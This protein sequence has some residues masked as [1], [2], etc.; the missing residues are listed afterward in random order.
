MTFFDQGQDTVEEEVDVGICDW[1]PTRQLLLLA[2]IG[3]D[4]NCD[5]F[6]IKF[7]EL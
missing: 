4:K 6:W 1:L 7:L 3:A 5:P 2:A